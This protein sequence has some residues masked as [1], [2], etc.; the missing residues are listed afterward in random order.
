MSANPL[1]NKVRL[2][3]L[4]VTF[5]V[6]TQEQLDTALEEQKKTG[7][8]LGEAIR[9]LGYVS[10]ETMIEFLGRQ[11]NIPH[12]DLEKVVPDK[13]AINLVPESLARRHK[14][15]PISKVGKLMTLAMADPLDVFAIDDIGA[16][17]GFEISP[18]VSAER[19]IIKA[20][21]KYYWLQNQETCES[22]TVVDKNVL[23]ALKAD[24]KN[25]IVISEN[26]VVKLVNMILNQAIV[27][28]A[29]DVHVEPDKDELRIRHRVDGILHEVMSVPKAVEANVVSRLKIMANIDIAEKRAPQDGRCSISLGDKEVDLRMSTLPTI[30]G[31]KVVLRILEKNAVNVGLESLGFDDPDLLKV[32]RIINKPYGMV[33]VSGPTGSGKT[34]TLYAALNNVVSVEKNIVTIEDPVEYRLKLTNQVQV[35]PKAG[36]TFASGL[37]SI[38]RQDPDI[39][40]VGEIRDE[41]TAEIAVHSALSGHLVFST[42]HTND[43]AGSAA[44]FIEMGIEPFLI[45]SSILGVVAQRLVRLLC[46]VCKEAYTPA[47][48]L[49]QRLDLPLDRDL[50]FYRAKGCPECKGTGYKGREGIYEVLTFTDEIKNLVVAKATAAQIRDAAIKNDFRTLRDSG[51]SK[52]IQGKTSLEAV[53][54]VTLDSELL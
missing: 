52:V 18:V 39:I 4:L 42:I 25:D 47:P 48:E 32:R 22:T 23:N 16:A 27:D 50:V 3:E 24:I 51:I 31:E 5:G 10:E 40:M 14:A 11:L 44:R 26:H 36:V 2:G 6:I 9:K 7:M 13:A 8:R 29:S 49:L 30:F 15:I 43:A 21:D 28:K 17:S 19:N 35:N 37:R 38:V 53:L 1:G 20:I 45:A 41:E 46:P 33:L 34:T 12:V 54:K